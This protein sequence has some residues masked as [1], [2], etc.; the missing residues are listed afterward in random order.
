MPIDYL[1]MKPQVQAMTDH[2]AEQA[3]ISLDLL[4]ELKLL[5]DTYNEEYESLQMRIDSALVHSPMLRCASPGFEPLKTVIAPPGEDSTLAIILA[6]DGSQIN[7]SRHDAVEFGMVNLGCFYLLPGSGFAPEIRTRCHLLYPGM[8]LLGNETLSEE[9]VALLRDVEERRF[10]AEV[11]VQA[12]KEIAIHSDGEMLPIVAFTDGP[13]ELFGEPGGQAQ[14]R[15]R[16]QDYLIALD[17]MADVGAVS[18]GYVD[19]PRANL[20]IKMLELMTLSEDDLK[21]EQWQARFSGIEDTQLFAELLL[22]GYRTTTYLLVSRS[23]KTFKEKSARLT[24]CFFYINVGY[25]L[26]DGSR[27]DAYARVEVPLW[28]AQDQGLMAL[29]H[30]SIL[31]QCKI[32]GEQPYPYALHRA[33]EVAVVRF[34]EK[35]E[36]QQLIH[37]EMLSRGLVVENNSMKSANKAVAFQGRER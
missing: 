29:L 32:L 3:K 12:Q 18:A 25:Y 28:V 11:A 17:H 23:A 33:H 16:F 21:R 27:M 4:E 34:S 8:P 30:R 19:K 9:L 7:P 22:P 26:R 1:D 35:S 6:S 5:L 15:K 36:I 14:Q 31:D 37:A 2:F 20:I 24:L 10:V 13:L